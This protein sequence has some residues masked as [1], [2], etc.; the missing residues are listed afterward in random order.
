MTT[1][2]RGFA[3]VLAAY[4]A[5]LIAAVL[6]GVYAA[7]QGASEFVV[8]AVADAVATVVVFGASVAFRNSSFYDA[9]WSVAPPLLFA[10][11]IIVGSGFD[12]RMG[13]ACLVVLLWA[14]RLTWNWA[15]GW[16]G[17]THEDWRYEDLKA[18]TG[19]AYWLVNFLGI[20]FFPTVLVF[21]GCVPLWVVSRSYEPLWWLDGAALMLGLFAVWLQWA[22]DNALHKFRVERSSAQQVLRAGLWRR[23]RHPNYLGE[24]LFWS[25][26]ALFGIAAGGAWWVLSGAALMVLLFVGISIPMIDKRML[27]NKPAYADYRAATP[28]LL[29]RLR[30]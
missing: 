15:R 17:L 5:A 13:M 26:L 8:A 21:I 25:S 28:A 14:L 24:I 19:G 18:Q 27:A 23:C 16:E 30:G 11:W 12:A 6:A 22:S 20:H 3:L 4:L 2:G 7:S 29:P 1:R 9:Y 10:F